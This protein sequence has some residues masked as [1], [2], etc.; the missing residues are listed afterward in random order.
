METEGGCGQ[1]GCGVN[2]GNEN[3]E[4]RDKLYALWPQDGIQ[5]IS[6]M[7]LT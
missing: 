4:Q 7:K 5:G 1:K 2:E 3:A 6:Q